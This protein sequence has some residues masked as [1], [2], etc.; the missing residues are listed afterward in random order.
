MAAADPS[1]DPNPSPLAKLLRRAFVWNYKRGGWGVETCGKLPKKFVLIAVPHTSNWDF[2][3]VLGAFNM[4]GFT[5][6][7]IAKD[8]LFKWPMGDFMRGM[9]GVP[10]DRNA[11]AGLVEQMAAEFAAREEF[12]LTIAP[13]GTRGAVDKWKTGFYRIAMAARVPIGCGFMDYQRRLSGIGLL[14]EPTGDYDADMQPAYDFYR[15]IV[16]HNPAGFRL[17]D[18]DDARP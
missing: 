17:P 12:V 10:V 14:I 1:A 3:N 11:A 8:T 6:R 4:I 7:F 2:P 13:E 5:P 16:P 15:N 18:Q 9:G